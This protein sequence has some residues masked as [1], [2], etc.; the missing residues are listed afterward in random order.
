MVI[1]QEILNIV[2]SVIDS[3]GLNLYHMDFN[4]SILR[5]MVEANDNPVTIETCANVARI[6]SSKLDLVNLIPY[7]YNIEVSSPGI[8]RGLYEPKHY[9][10][11]AGE[12]CRLSTKFGTF[13]GK[14]IDADERNLKVA[15]IEKNTVLTGLKYDEDNKYFIIPFDDIKSG[16]LKVSDEVLFAKSRHHEVVTKEK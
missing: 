1:K 6:L 4:R 14:I 8:E 12:I 2:Q 16:Q 15:P 10:R 11:F 13:L 9:K 7:R 5:I 3:L